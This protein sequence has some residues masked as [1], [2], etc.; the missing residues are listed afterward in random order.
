MYPEP[1]LD[2]YVYICAA[3]M[4]QQRSHPKTMDV[5]RHIRWKDFEIYRQREAPGVLHVCGAALL[6]SHRVHRPD[7]AEY[8]RTSTPSASRFE[9]GTFPL[10]IRY[11]AINS[12]TMLKERKNMIVCLHNWTAHLVEP[13]LRIQRLSVN[14]LGFR[15]SAQAN[16]RYTQNNDLH[17]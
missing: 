10:P 15:L 13:Y 4:V 12:L 6:R 2:R 1:K 5:R 11:N 8:S 7:N 16:A 9:G 3:N 17:P 14:K